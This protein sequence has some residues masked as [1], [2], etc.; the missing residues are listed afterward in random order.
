MKF[1][2]Q[3]GSSVFESDLL[4]WKLSF[5]IVPDY[6]EWYAENA[7]VYDISFK[8]N[9]LFGFELLFQLYRIYILSLLKIV[10]VFKIGL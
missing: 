9:N 7:I 10:T 2:L 4:K 1:L 8:K 5:G 6:R 3:I